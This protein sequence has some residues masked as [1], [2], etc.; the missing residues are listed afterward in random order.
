MKKSKEV[1]E[2]WY[3]GN[4]DKAWKIISL[5]VCQET[6]RA[7]LPQLL[8]KVVGPSIMDFIVIGTV[9]IPEQLTTIHRKIKPIKHKT[10]FD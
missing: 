1:L 5:I 8:E 10:R 4:L 7:D 3:G 2:E 6:N 9:N